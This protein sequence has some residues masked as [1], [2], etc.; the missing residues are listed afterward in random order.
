MFRR[1]LYNLNG[2]IDM[3]N[4]KLLPV[5]CVL[6]A[7]GNAKRFGEDKLA[8]RIG[9][10]SLIEHALAS[11]PADGLAAVCVVT[12]HDHVIHKAEQYGFPCVFND[13]PQEGIS[14]TVRLGTQ[15]LQ[16]RC[17]AILYMVADQP[18][19]TRSSVAAML[20]FYRLHPDRIVSASHDGQ[21][22]NPCI[23]PARYF[24]ELCALQG[25]RGGRAV[26]ERHPED[27]L[28]FEID[29]QELADID[30]R[31]ALEALQK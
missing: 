6:M 20:A 10:S 13:R 19:L 28:L 25:D 14:R 18:Q 5:G 15:A 8:A 2:V 30:T 1:Y 24:P 9:G 7:A 22:G 29:A 17:A 4:E 11:V 21:R 12:Q 26:I 31:A 16:D 23:F 3:S 27:L